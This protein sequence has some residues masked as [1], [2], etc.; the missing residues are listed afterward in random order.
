MCKDLFLPFFLRRSQIRSDETM[1]NRRTYAMN[2]QMNITQCGVPWPVEQN[3]REL[4]GHSVERV[5]LPRNTWSTRTYW[6]QHIFEISCYTELYRFW[7]S[8]SMV[9]NHLRKFSHADPDS[10][11][12]QNRILV[13]SPPNLPTKFPNL[14]TTFWDILFT[15]TQ[16]DGV[17]T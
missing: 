13:T 10:D 12:H 2:I 17:K 6:A 16:T 9:K 14:S 15:N 3:T 1:A 8:H 5:P 11:L 7:P 4:E